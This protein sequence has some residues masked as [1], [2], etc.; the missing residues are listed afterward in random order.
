MLAARSQKASNR[1]VAAVLS[2]REVGSSMSVASASA[3][4]IPLGRAQVVVGLDHGGDWSLIRT[5]RVMPSPMMTAESDRQT[6]ND[7]MRI[8]GSDRCRET[9]DVRARYRHTPTGR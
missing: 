6:M 5:S 1:V 2:V 7:L 3:G 9:A 4:Q 8:H